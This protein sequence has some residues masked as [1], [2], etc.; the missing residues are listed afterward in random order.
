MS[1]NA[2][3][4]DRRNKLGL[5]KEQVC[6]I[7]GLSIHEYSDLEAYADEFYSVLKLREV[8]ALSK[9]LKLELNELLSEAGIEACVNNDNAE[10]EL[11]RSDLVKRRRELLGLSEDEL[12]DKLG[13][14]PEAIR[15]MESEADFFEGWPLDLIERLSHELGIPVSAILT[16]N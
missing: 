16:S 12:A 3:I 2:A 9:A 6:Q 10:S 1:I 11:P 13:F 14:D 8:K 7:V 15:R 4:R 5:A